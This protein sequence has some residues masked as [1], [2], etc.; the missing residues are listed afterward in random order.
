MQQQ[1]T[2]QHQDYHHHARDSRVDHSGQSESAGGEN[3][4]FLTRA[5][6]HH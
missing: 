3:E 5:V 6:A 1:A 4:F 2:P